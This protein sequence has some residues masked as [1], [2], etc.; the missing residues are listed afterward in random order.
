MFFSLRR[1]QNGEAFSKHVRERL[2]G[3][4][5]SPLS[6][7]RPTSVCQ[8]C[9]H[10]TDKSRMFFSNALSPTRLTTNVGAARSH[11]DQEW[12]TKQ[13]NCSR[14]QKIAAISTTPICVCTVV[15]INANPVFRSDNVRLKYFFPD[16][17]IAWNPLPAASVYLLHSSA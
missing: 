10:L 16:P 11:T 9:T 4:Y 8:I 3:H 2:T 17:S 14:C 7:S 12:R 6:L 1:A 5:F 13:Q 15:G